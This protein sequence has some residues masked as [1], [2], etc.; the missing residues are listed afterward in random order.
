MKV[1]AFVKRK[2]SAERL[3]R[4]FRPSELAIHLHYGGEV[5][6]RLL[7]P[8][9]LDDAS[10]S[11]VAPLRD[12]AIDDLPHIPYQGI[13]SALVRERAS[14]LDGVVTISATLWWC[15]GAITATTSGNTAYG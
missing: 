11:I 15:S 10:A 12:K 9:K 4:R 13:K 6:L 5:T 7:V 2:F 3:R 8:D 14:F 1:A